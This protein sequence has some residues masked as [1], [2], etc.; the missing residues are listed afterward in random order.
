[1][2][3]NSCQKALQK[4][5][6][7]LSTE[8]MKQWLSLYPDLMTVALILKR[9]LHQ[10]GLNESYSGGLSSYC[11][12]MMIISTLKPIKDFEPTVKTGSGASHILLAFLD[13]YGNHFD[14]QRTG[15]S[16]F[17]EPS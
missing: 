6:G 14:L 2:E 10:R 3:G 15:I 5:M 13:F 4:H 16:V 17:L 7:L 9:L 11:L 12:L 1:M 8:M